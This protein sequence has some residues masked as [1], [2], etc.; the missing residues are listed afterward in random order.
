MEE[1]K[2]DAEYLKGFN[3]GYILSQHEPEFAKQISQIENPTQN[4]QGFRDGRMQYFNEQMKDFRRSWSKE[5]H[6]NEPD[7][8]KDKDKDIDLE[9][10]F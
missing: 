9:Q 2:V 4:L 8:T 5:F 7:I 6:A 10:N 1:T 3:N